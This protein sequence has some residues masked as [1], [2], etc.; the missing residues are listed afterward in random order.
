MQMALSE[1]AVDRLYEVIGDR[2]R[3]ARTRRRMTQADLGK[4]LNLTRSSVANIEAGRQRVMIHTL[5]QIADH[6]EVDIETLLVRPDLSNRP[7][8]HVAPDELEGQPPTTHEFLASALR[9][10]AQA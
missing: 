6:L 3:A 10:A 4:R 8:E 9:R 5:F 1:D 2:I 7:A